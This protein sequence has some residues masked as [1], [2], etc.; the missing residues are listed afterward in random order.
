MRVS[1]SRRE[2]LAASAAVVASPAIAESKTKKLVLIAGTPSHPPGMHEFNAGVQILA[3]CLKGFPGLDVN[4]NLNGWPKN[5]SVFDDAAG[6]LIYA[7]GGERHPG[8]QM[9]RLA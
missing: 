5:Q 6:I 3:K 8:G 9:D 7:D 1:I 4:V 2:F